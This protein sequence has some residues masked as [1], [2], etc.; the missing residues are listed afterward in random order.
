MPTVLVVDDSTI[1]RR[2]LATRF[3]SDGINVREA[4]SVHA[5]RAVDCDS[6]SCAILDLQL[7]DGD[8][9]DLAAALHKRRPSLP[10]AF[11]TGG[12]VPSLVESARCQ[13][14]VFLKTD[15]NALLAWVRRA[16][17]PSQPPPTK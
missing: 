12:G 5:A 16:V 13:G 15:L 9:T 1:I 7:A 11:F 14:P 2:A 17:R 6:L 4:G 10:I 8:G 3:S